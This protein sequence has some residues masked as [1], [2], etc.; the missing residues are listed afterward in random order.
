MKTGNQ[1]KVVVAL[2]S[3]VALGLS[4]PAGAGTFSSST[5]APGLKASDIANLRQPTGSDKW[6]FSGSNESGATDAAKGQTFTTGPSAVLFKAL[7]YK[8][9]ATQKKTA[10]TVYTIRVGLVSGTNFT[11]ITSETCTQTVD[12]PV[13][14]YITWTLDRPVLLSP[15]TTYGVDVAMKS[16]TA[17]QTGIPYLEYTANT[18]H[19]RIGAFYNSGDMGVG[20]NYIVIDSSKDRVFHVDLEDPLRPCPA[21]GAT[22]PAGDVQLSWRNLTPNVGSDVYVDVWFG[23]NAGALTRIMTGGRNTTNTTVSAPVAATYYWRV[24]SYLDGAPTGTPV[25]GTLFRFVV[26]D[27]D[28]DGL[29]DDYELA[30]TTPPSPT[31][32]NPGDDLDHDGLTNMREFQLGTDPNKLDTDGDGLGD[33]AELTGAGARPPT[34]P[35][36][37]DT[38]GDGLSDRVETNT[39]I[40]VNATDTGTNPAQADT[41]SDGLRDGVETNTGVFVSATNTGTHPLLADSDGDDAGD[42]YEV[43]ATYTDPNDPADKPNVPYPLP[44]PD[45]TPPATN[46]PVKV[47]ILSGQSNMVG[48][49][50]INP[51]NTPGTLSTIVKQEGKFP[52]LLDSNGNWTIRT[53]VWYRGVISAIGN[54]PLTVGQGSSSSTI[55][56]ELGFGH[57]MGYYLDEPV[58]IIKASIG[59]RS[60]LWDCLPPGSPRFDYNGYTYAGYGDSPNYW[61]IG[62][63]PSPYVWYAGK[64]YDDYFLDEADMGPPAWVAGLNYPANCQVRHNGVVYIC[65]S[66]HT[67]DANSEPGIGANWG[68]YWNV[69]SVFNVV[70][71]LDNWAREYPQWAAQGFRIAGFVWFQ[72]NKDL[73]EPAASRYETNLVNLIRCVRSYYA[74]RYPGKCT[75][76]TP[77]VVAVGCGDPGTSGYGLVVAQ[78]QLA[79]SGERGKY[80]DFVGNVKTVD[81]R[82]YWRDAAQSPANQGYHYNRNAETF[83]LIG[84]AIGRG[85]IELLSAQAGNDYSRWAA[86]WPGA[87]LTDPKADL[88]G[89]GLSNNYERIWGLDPTDAASRS[90]FRDLSSLPS[91]T[92]S[93]LRRKPSLTGYRYTVWTSTDLITWVE[94]AGAVQTSTPVVGDVETVTV[95]L[96][97]ALLTQPRLFVRVCALQ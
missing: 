5:N 42:W 84:D 74:N 96:S 76:N 75:T 39:G 41:D 49:G 14:A 17:W 38:D 92:F 13:G 64:Q 21:D 61:P 46:K 31:A 91:G 93:Y 60:L 62:G 52:Y 53:D 12:T 40:W 9:D 18:N 37:V 65:K 32:L 33:G 2:A 89:D 83:M 24:D 30:H 29:P 73:G 34:N 69:Y 48:M 45:S 26:I 90:P 67:S 10:P 20:T 82:G 36:R 68:T 80:P 51:T 43:T 58:L 27:T 4:S 19:P 55:G 47:F 23:T 1:A 71:I 16:Q 54:A 97:P 11:L 86:Q 3:S 66:A 77:F 57:V 35:L 7:T 8:I 22:V 72:G 87:N 15:N 70:D 63:S 56:P 25:I 59:N 88:D 94:D 79:V 44:R 85:M 95:S 78:A 6:W 50:D 28:G 81:T